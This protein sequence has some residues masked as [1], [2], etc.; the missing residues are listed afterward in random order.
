M[1]NF[2]LQCR[3]R[4]VTCSIPVGHSDF[5][6]CPTLVLLI[7]SLFTY[8]VF[9]FPPYL[10]DEHTLAPFYHSNSVL[11]LLC[12][13]ERGTCLDRLSDGNLCT[14]LKIKQFLLKAYF[15]AG[16]LLSCFHFIEK[17]MRTSFFLLKKKQLNIRPTHPYI[18]SAQIQTKLCRTCIEDYISL[19]RRRHKLDHARVFLNNFTEMNIIN[20]LAS[21]VNFMAQ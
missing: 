3:V 21:S 10:V 19:V 2:K 11:Q 4:E 8:L 18:S 16:C 20:L 1:V 17:N 12:I 5:F 14:H 13:S 15:I 6:L 9:F 7:N